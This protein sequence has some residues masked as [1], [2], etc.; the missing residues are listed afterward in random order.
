M[1]RILYCCL[2]LSL[3]LASASCKTKR[4]P[5]GKQDKVP[6]AAKAAEPSKPSFRW[7]YAKVVA[8]DRRGLTADA[9][10]PR[11]SLWDAG[12]EGKDARDIK[13]TLPYIAVQDAKGRVFIADKVAHSVRRVDEIQEIHT[14]AGTG[15]QS[16]G[17]DAIQPG[18]ECGLAF[19][20]ALWAHPS[21]RL[22]LLDFGNAK[23]RRL[24]EDGKIETLFDLP[25]T[26]KGGRGLVV[27][28]DESVIYVAAKDRIYRYDGHGAPKLFAQGFVNLGH[29]LL[30]PSNELIAADRDAGYVYQVDEQ[31]H[32]SILA[33]DG[34]VKTRPGAVLATKQG[35]NQP[36]ALA[37]VPQVG[38]L[39]GTQ[40]GR[41]V[42]RLSPG[43]TLELLLDGRA[44]GKAIQSPLALRIREP[45]GKMRG[46]SLAPNGDLLLTHGDVGQVL[47]FAKASS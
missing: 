12:F 6:A 22:Y 21:G 30:T 18:P 28:P 34:T 32:K 4:S 13:L 38:L 8:G 3:S 26:L 17:K 9:P 16:D 20:N 25:K 45:L 36:R 29:L 19:P 1:S 27:R 24:N 33:G 47:R 35:L 46:L 14:A 2:W 41:R 5:E 40:S 23:L 15:H 10:A 37:W 39:I 44:P 11:H 42:Y 43:G 31:G 7:S